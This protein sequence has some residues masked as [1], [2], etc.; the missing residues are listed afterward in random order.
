M[1]KT[2][3]IIFLFILVL[4]PFYQVS[5]Q[6]SNAAAE[7]EIAFDTAGLPLWV[8]DVR[9][10]DIIAF[11]TYPFS[12]FLATFF[13]DLYRWNHNNGMEFSSEGRRYAPWPFKS[14]GAVD[15]TSQEFKKNIFI[16]AGIS[17]AFALVDLLIVKLR[18]NREKRRIES[19]PSSRGT[20]TVERRSAEVPVKT[21][22]HEVLSDMEII[23]LDE[24]PSD[25][26]VIEFDEPPLE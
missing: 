4:S 9:R 15:L 10:F 7:E 3:F 16:A 25:M 20:Y 23:E 21:E 24:H 12:M 17:A 11:G 19:L 5:A 8:K 13:H 1:K 6:T 2:V 14:A 18:Q 26:N 22:V